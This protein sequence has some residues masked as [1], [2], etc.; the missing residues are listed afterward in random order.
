MDSTCSQLPAFVP[1]HEVKRK[2]YQGIL[3]TKTHSMR[4]DA[5]RITT[6]VPVRFMHLEGLYDLFVAK[7]VI[8]ITSL[9]RSVSCL[10][11]TDW[12]HSCVYQVSVDVKPM[13]QTQMKFQTNTNLVYISICHLLGIFAIFVI[14]YQPNHYD[15]CLTYVQMIRWGWNKCPFIFPFIYNLSMWLN[16]TYNNSDYGQYAELQNNRGLAII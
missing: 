16:M 9:I 6:W 10:C 11:T 4:F 15:N 14:F 13:N 2:A 7:L 3:G 5:D 1:V 12:S 8:H